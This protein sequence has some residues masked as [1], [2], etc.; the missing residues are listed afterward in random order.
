MSKLLRIAAVSVVLASCSS[1]DDPGI[2]VD[3]A[4]ASPS[5]PAVVEGVRT[6]ET[7][8]GHRIVLTKAYLATGSVGLLACLDHDHHHLTWGE[9]LRRLIVADAH[10]HS[11]SSPVQLGIPV[12]E[13]LLAPAGERIH[14]GTMEPPPGDYCGLRYAAFAADHD[15]AGLPED[16]SME[17]KT[18][19]LEG[20]FEPADGSAA[21]AFQIDSAESFEIDLI[22][23]Q[24]EL[25]G[26]GELEASFSLGKSGDHWFDDL[27]LDTSADLSEAIGTTFLLRLR[28]SL[29]VQMP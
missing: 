17:G 23:P 1:S 19:Y 3:V 2:E 26:S 14:V 15:A 21:V 13:S 16:V 6:F 29:K 25:G 8:Q 5:S 7:N 10:A 27:P 12:V 18:L 22:F 9:R 20:L 4:I 28:D 24:L 11:M